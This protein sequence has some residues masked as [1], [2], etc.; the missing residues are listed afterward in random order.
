MRSSQ[1]MAAD[2]ERCNGSAAGRA[3]TATVVAVGPSDRLA[4]VAAILARARTRPGALHIVRI[5]I[6]GD[7]AGRAEERPDVV[8]I[9]GLQP[10]V[11]Q[12]RDCGG[13]AVEPADDRLV[14]RR[15]ARGARRR[16]VAGRS[17]RSS[18]PTIRGRSGRGRRR[19]SSRR[20]FTDMRWAR[21]T[22]WRA[23]LA[24]FF[25][26]PAVRD[27]RAPSSARCRSP[28]RIAPWRRSSPA[29]STRRSAGAA[30]SR[31]TYRRRPAA[32][33]SSR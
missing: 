4:D 1:R 32:R 7:G 3:R 15:P 25:D 29:G 5:A 33:R 12:Q 31:R 24:H 22:R 11:R 13:P 9:G 30:G 17:G 18:T 14:A 8:T 19:S 2:G 23:A 27:E 6:D 21:L 10:R 28:P 16:R 26:L 20:R